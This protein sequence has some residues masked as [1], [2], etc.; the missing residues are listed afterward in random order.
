MIILRFLK[1]LTSV[2][3]KWWWA[4]LTAIATFIPLFSLPAKS[5]LSNTIIAIIIF[6]FFLMIF[7]T[8]SVISRGYKWY[9]GSH[10]APSVM[11]CISALT[12][13][14]EEIIT[15]SSVYELEIGQILTVLRTTNRGTGCFGLI[16]VDRRLSSLSDKYQCSP[17]WI[18]PVHRNDLV[19]NQVQI[20]Q[21]STSLFLNYNDLVN[22][23][24]GS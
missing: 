23:L 6:V 9:L 3:F 2:F 15:I 20:T 16:K 1:D 14:N 24:K 22:L 7:L 21:L 19:Q 10:N 13:Q 8:L 17:L 12:G 11:S 5:T 4:L 18:A